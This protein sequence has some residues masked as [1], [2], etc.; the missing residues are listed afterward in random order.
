MKSPS[1][2]PTKKK[3]RR[4]QDS[5]LHDFESISSN[6]C[7]IV[8]EGGRDHGEDSDGGDDPQPRILF[9]C[10]T[11][12][13]LPVNEHLQTMSQARR[14]TLMA[15]VTPGSVTRNDLFSGYYDRPTRK[16]NKGAGPYM[17]TTIL[18]EKA[19][20]LNHCIS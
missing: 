9:S 17:N 5:S 15:C 18:D 3:P 13:G 14:M 7:P 11:S 8:E 6:H 1:K 16:W 20:W 2:S 4:Q 12:V 19:A 10:S